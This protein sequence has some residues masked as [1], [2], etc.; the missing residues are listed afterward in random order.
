MLDGA[1]DAIARKGIEV[2]D[3]PVPLVVVMFRNNV[4]FQAYRPM[5]PGVLAWYDM[6]SNHVILH[7]ESTQANTQPDVARAVLLS[8]IAHEGAH[9]ILHNIGVQQ[10]L[11]LWP[12]WLSEG[13]A[14]FMAPTSVGRN[15]RWK[16]AGKVNDFR[17]FDLETYLQS[18]YIAGFNGET[19]QRYVAAPQLDYTGYATAWAIVHYLAHERE[20]EFDQLIKRM[21]RLGPMR[22]M[23]SRPGDPVIENLEHFS[24][25]FGS[26][27]AAIE[28]DMV[29]YLTRL[30]YSSPMSDFVHY[31]GF[32][33]IPLDGAE[34]RLAC[35]FHT[36]ERVESWK[37]QLRKTY[38]DDQLSAAKWKIEEFDNRAAA[39]RAIRR[40][41]N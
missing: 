2:H 39:N 21:S 28:T 11:S 15:N 29:D 37:E 34:K 40:F 25:F 17:M 4:E 38:S 14:E 8:T 26:D 31:V 32:V 10:R 33:S 24:E 9:Q 18:Q 20:D 36:R 41:L 5:A 27:L 35:F 7:Q 3:P 1:S 19:V 23:A 22:G 6:V 30:E 13:L 16:G 12:M